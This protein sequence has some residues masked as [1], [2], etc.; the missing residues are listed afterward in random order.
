MHDPIVAGF[1]EQSGSIFISGPFTPPPAE[2]RNGA[3]YNTS[4][5]LGC[6]GTEKGYE[7]V[8]CVQKKS[9]KEILDAMPPNLTGFMSTVG[10][11]GPT[12]DDITVFRNPYKLGRE[13]KF[14]PRV[15]V[16]SHC[17]PRH[18]N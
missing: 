15:S 11:F 3:W 10:H 4:K 12:Y 1:I 9:V 2:Y 14:I 13:G 18:A 6:G 16:L 8:K 5:A 17:N 7:T